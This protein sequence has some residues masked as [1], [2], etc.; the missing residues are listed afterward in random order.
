MRLTTVLLVV[1]AAGL[2]LAVSDAKDTSRGGLDATPGDVIAEAAAEAVETEDGPS[3]TDVPA[4]VKAKVATTF[5]SATFNSIVMTIAT[6]L[7]DKTF[8]IAAVMAM[9][10]N[11]LFV[12]AGGISALLVMTVLSVGIGVAVPTL[13]P[14]VYTHYAAAALFFYFGVKLLKEAREMSIAGTGGSNEELA[15]AEEELGF[16]NKEEKGERPSSSTSDVESGV[17]MSAGSSGARPRGKGE[18]GA[19]D[20]ALSPA[21]SPALPGGSVAIAVAPGTG[22]STSASAPST[23]PSS[24][25]SSPSLFAAPTPKDWAVLTQAFT[26]TF[27]AEWGDRSQIATIAMAAAQNAFGVCMGAFVGHSL[28][29][30]LAVIGGRMLASRISERTVA[31]MGGVLFLLFA[32]HSVIAGPDVDE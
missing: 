1:A 28:C 7:G 27:L 17:A 29:T 2:L 32:L 24:S 20:A 15:E 22:S 3:A 10:Y 23:A 18:G 16:S 13:L 11:R 12:F 21:S 26:I 30:G 5:T 19:S 9:R 14:K 31:W 8:C 25:S 6:E 4:V